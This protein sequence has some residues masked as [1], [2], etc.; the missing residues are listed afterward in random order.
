MTERLNFV[1]YF[2]TDDGSV[3]R[4]RETPAEVTPDPTNRGVW[5]VCFA[6]G[7]DV[8]EVILRRDG[9]EF[10]GDCWAV[11]KTGQRVER[12]RGLVYS[13]GPCAHLWRV[14]SDCQPLDVQQRRAED[15]VEKMRADGGNLRGGRRD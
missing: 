9:D 3:S 12:C 1:G 13:D 5:L 14:R 6:D 2:D 11:D 10:R 15:A 8:H 4:A 7:Q